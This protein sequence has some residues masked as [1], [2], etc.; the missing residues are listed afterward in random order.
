MRF[1]YSTVTILLQMASLQHRPV[2]ARHPF[3]CPLHFTKLFPTQNSHHRGRIYCPWRKWPTLQGGNTFF[4]HK[5][6][7]FLK[8]KSEILN[9]LLTRENKSEISNFGPQEISISKI[10]VTW[11]IY[12]R[13]DCIKNI[14]GNFTSVRKINSS[15]FL[16]T[17][18]ALSHEE[19]IR[20]T[21]DSFFRKIEPF[22]TFEF[23]GFRKND[24][25]IKVLVANTWA[26]SNKM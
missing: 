9:G 16:V 19:Y 22:P 10:D 18:D 3:L 5:K 2:S 20:V 8:V 1:I 15:D 6:I 11:K 14:L 24:F 7:H 17:S 13:K 26:F 25:Y 4:L 12:W 23:A 21:N